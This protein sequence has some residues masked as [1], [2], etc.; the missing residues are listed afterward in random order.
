MPAPG[1]NTTIMPGAGNLAGRGTRQVGRGAYDLNR[2]AQQTYRR[3]GSPAMLMSMDYRNNILQNRSTLPPMMPPQAMP[4]SAAPQGTFRPGFNGSQIYVPP[5]PADAM[6]PSPPPLTPPADMMPGGDKG[7]RSMLPGPPVPAIPS[8]PPPGGFPFPPLAPSAS[9]PLP[10]STLGGNVGLPPPPAFGMQTLGGWEVLTQNTPEGVKFLNARPAPAPAPP[11]LSAADLGRITAAGY[12]PYQVD[13]K[14]FDA[15]GIPYLRKIPAP[16]ETVTID[17]VTGE[18]RTFKRPVQAAPA[19][20][21]TPAAPVPSPAST[22]VSA[23][24]AK[25]R[26]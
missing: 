25:M 8:A 11:S 19:P 6:M 13:G 23:A 15:Q 1:E 20:T 4:P 5:P 24:L 17:P 26:K 12:E 21:P 16:M 3:T 7:T 22:A 2:I 10:P 9:M 18:R 14:S